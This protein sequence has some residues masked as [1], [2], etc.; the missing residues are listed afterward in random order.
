M[1]ILEAL[2]PRLSPTL[3]SCKWRNE[4]MRCD[5]I[6]AQILTEEG[7]CYTFNNLNQDEIFR[8]DNLH[9]DFR[10]IEHSDMVGDWTVEAGYKGNS[11]LTG[12]PERVSSA[13]ARAGLNII[14]PLSTYDKDYLC[15]GPS[16]G[17][18]VQLHAPGEVP[19]LSQ[20]YF[21]LSPDQEMI[22]SVKPNMITT[23]EVLKSYEISRRMCYFQNERYLRFF[24]VYTQPNCELEC[25]TNYTLRKC[26][27]VKFSMPRDAQTKICG[28]RK[29][30]CYYQA[31]DELFNPF[32]GTPA[33]EL[34][35]DCLPSCTSV[36]YD[37]ETS[38][39]DFDW[40]Q[41]LG[42]YGAVSGSFPGLV[43]GL[44]CVLV[45][46]FSFFQGPT[47]T[48]SNLLSGQPIYCLKAI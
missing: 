12:Y 34:G 46:N 19:R 32:E 37:A 29:L 48:H 24:K 31:E 2:T 44:G 9:K 4:Q 43:I 5:T 36:S 27:C 39:A 40:R 26:G 13:G 35:C 17:F 41:F 3:F 16:Q 1:D 22:L 15:R 45:F 38:Q 20:K 30:V 14:L 42:A 6:F 11:S 33:D 7:I 21:R 47:W 23:S 25:L 10:Y 28:A 18:K 8:E